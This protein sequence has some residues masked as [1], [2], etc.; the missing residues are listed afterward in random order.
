MAVA[1]FIV[2]AF[3]VAGWIAYPLLTK[4]TY[5]QQAPIPVN[6]GDQATRG[7]RSSRS[8]IAYEALQGQNGERE[9]VCPSCGQGYRVGDRFCVRCGQALP[10]RL[11]AI[12]AQ[13]ALPT[14]TCSSCGALLRQ[15][16]QFCAKCGAP[17]V[18]ALSDVKA[19]AGEDA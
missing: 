12:Q 14:L 7:R 5:A 16:D 3:L 10:E 13:N 15:E 17:V 19:D 1:I 4:Q 18:R 11:E 8:K 9:L 6:G 2:L